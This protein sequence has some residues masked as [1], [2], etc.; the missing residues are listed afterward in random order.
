MGKES[1]TVVIMTSIESSK[2]LIMLDDFTLASN[3]VKGT[4]KLFF[5]A[6][7]DLLPCSNFRTCGFHKKTEGLVLTSVLPVFK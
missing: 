5:L 6:Y 4:S 3:N 7:V 1:S 2:Y